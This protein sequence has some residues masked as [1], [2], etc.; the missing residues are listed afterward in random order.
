MHNKSIF[1][2]VIIVIFIVGIIG[3][4]PLVYEDIMVGDVCPKLIGIPACYVILACFV[5]PFVAHVLKLNSKIYFTGVLLA[6]L[7]A[8]YGSIRQLL[9]LGNCPKTDQ[10]IPMC[11]ISF[12]FFLMLFILKLVQIKK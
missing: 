11:F 2:F 10:L 3:T 7:I 6:L 5:I 1:Y 12:V 9:N 8:I 4:L